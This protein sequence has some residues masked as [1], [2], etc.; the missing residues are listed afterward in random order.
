M[1]DEA[2]V[3]L[4]WARDDTA[5]SET[6]SKYG[7]YL[8]RI[9]QRLVRQARDS[10]ECVNDTYLGAWNAMPPQR[11]SVLQTFLGK[12][13]RR[14]A[15]DRFRKDT[16]QKRGGWSLP[17]SLNELG[18]CVPSQLSVEDAAEL[19]R[20]RDVVN[21]FIGTLPKEKRRAFLLRYWY[22]YPVQEIAALFGWSASKTSNLLL[23][24]RHALRDRL[25]EEG[26][27]HDGT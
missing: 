6:A 27:S 25:I 8:L 17:L 3:A 1:N 16:A 18:A 4:Y 22:A 23:R 2:I 12:L 5:I 19:H 14:I 20:L 11:P 7:A 26:F 10:E 24:L 21:S 15:I 9:A 13:T